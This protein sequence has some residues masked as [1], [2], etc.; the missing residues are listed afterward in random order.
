MPDSSP[1]NPPFHTVRLAITPEL[2][3]RG[4][5]HS[6]TH[7]PIALALRQQWPTANICVGPRSIHLHADQRFNGYSHTLTVAIK[8]GDW[9]TSYDLRR[10]KM[11]PICILLDFK[12]NIA[13]LTHQPPTTPGDPIHA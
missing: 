9:I 3:A 11:Q 12:H 13:C 4:L 5:A 2:I 10:H 1:P 7:C 6:Y 8:L